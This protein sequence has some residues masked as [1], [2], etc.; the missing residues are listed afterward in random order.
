MERQD[1]QREPNLSLLSRCGTKTK[2]ILPNGYNVQSD[3][4]PVI[5]EGGKNSICVSTQC[6]YIAKNF[7]L[8]TRQVFGLWQTKYWNSLMSRM[9]CVLRTLQEYF[10]SK[11]TISLTYCETSGEAETVKVGS[12]HDGKIPTVSNDRVMGAP[13]DGGR[14]RGRRPGAPPP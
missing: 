2:D 7:R 4:K 9:M 8:L 13:G 6:R 1:V 5:S 12:A 14:G 11:R 3:D 10:L